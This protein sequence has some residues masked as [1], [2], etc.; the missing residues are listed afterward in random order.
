MIFINMFVARV[1]DLQHCRHLQSCWRDNGDTIWHRRDCIGGECGERRHRRRH[2]GHIFAAVWQRSRIHSAA[3]DLYVDVTPPTDELIA[4]STD[5]V[6][7]TITF[8]NRGPST[9]TD[10]MLEVQLPDG[11]TR[12]ERRNRSLALLHRSSTLASVACTAA[13]LLVACTSTRS[14][15]A[16]R[17]CLRCKCAPTPTPSLTAL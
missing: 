7:F 5:D 15:T 10:V 11:V 3:L 2:H 6:T 14:T 12:V 13:R 4:G 8:G 17:S 16:K 1:V 9:G